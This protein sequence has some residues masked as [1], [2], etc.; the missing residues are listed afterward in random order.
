MPSSLSLRSVAVVE[1]DVVNLNDLELPSA[2]RKSRADRRARRAQAIR[3]A[4]R[5]A[6]LFGIRADQSVTWAKH[7]ADNLKMCSYWMCGHTRR[8]FGAPV[9][10]IRALGT[11][12]ETEE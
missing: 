8:W 1:F 5:V 6:T 2:P 11:V 3:R 10:E 12:S 4:L 9:A 7:N